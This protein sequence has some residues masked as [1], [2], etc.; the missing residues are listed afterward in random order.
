[1]VGIGCTPANSHTVDIYV[2]SG[3]G[4]PVVAVGK[5][6][7]NLFG[8]LGFADGLNALYLQGGVWGGVTRPLVLQGGGGDVY[9]EAWTD[10]SSSVQCYGWSAYTTKLFYYKKIGKMMFVEYYIDGTSSQT[11]ANISLPHTKSIGV[12]QL[13]I[14][15]TNSGTNITGLS[16]IVSFTAQIDF[17]STMGGQVWTASGGKMVTGQFWVECTA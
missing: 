12:I 15:A 13:P 17:Y 8:T 14:R 3:S 5:D 10:W 16:V 11:Y 4:D 2:P 9:T 1:M 7:T 6:Q